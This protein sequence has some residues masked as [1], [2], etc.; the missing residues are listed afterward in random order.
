M[1]R[2]SLAVEENR[3]YWEHLRLEIPK[4]KRAVVAFE[5]RWFRSK[6]M[7]RVRRLLAEFSHR[8]ETYPVALE[9]LLRWCPSD[10]RPMMRGRGESDRTS[11]YVVTNGGMS[12]PLPTGL[13]PAN[14]FSRDRKLE[15][16]TRV[17]QYCDRHYPNI[18]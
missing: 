5:K 7:E 11:I 10:R 1:L 9:V 12:F 18:N 14:A 15:W 6:S 2:V 8:D 3:A 16:Q 4:E 17:C 13:E